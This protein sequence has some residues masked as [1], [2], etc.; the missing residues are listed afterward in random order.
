[1]PDNTLTFPLQ[2]PTPVPTGTAFLGYQVALSNYNG[3]TQYAYYTAPQYDTT[4]GSADNTNAGLLQINRTTDGGTTWNFY[5]DSTS[6]SPTTARPGSIV[7]S[8]ASRGQSENRFGNAMGISDDGTLIAIAGMNLVAVYILNTSEPPSLD[9]LGSIITGSE[10]FTGGQIIYDIEVRGSANDLNAGVFLFFGR[11]GADGLDFYFLEYDSGTSD[12]TTPTNYSV[13]NASGLPGIS[14]QFATGFSVYVP[15]SGGTLSKDGI[16]LC[17]SDN[18]NSE[19]GSNG[20]QVFYYYGSS[21]SGWSSPVAIAGGGLISANS[22][23][24]FGVALSRNGK[25]LVVGEPKSFGN[26]PEVHVFLNDTDIPAQG[27]FVHQTSRTG[28]N[29]SN[30]GNAVGWNQTDSTPTQIIVGANIG[31]NDGT[32]K[33]A[34]YIYE[35]TAPNVISTNSFQPVE[36]TNTNQNQSRLGVSVALDSNAMAAL[37]GANGNS[38]ATPAGTVFLR[39]TGSAMMCLSDDTFILKM[40]EVDE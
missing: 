20:G 32:R 17:I 21:S 8:G 9:L 15:T 37:V 19:F 5:I 16:R 25:Y 27:S 6:I 22:R 38:T 39:Q 12:W 29:G 14:D 35:F 11:T 1:M 24:G 31:I 40:V 33:G 23:F 30:F 7:T 3:S 36:L 18:G 34:V 13:I 10:Y 2:N 28:P 26:D 4:G